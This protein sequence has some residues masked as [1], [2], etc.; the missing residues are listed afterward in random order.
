[1]NALEAEVDWPKMPSLGVIGAAID[2][3]KEDGTT[4]SDEGESGA[5]SGASLLGPRLGTDGG[6]GGGK[7]VTGEESKMSIMRRV[8]GKRGR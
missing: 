6:R 5:K 2:I 4:P 3:E 8:R 7:A 1:M